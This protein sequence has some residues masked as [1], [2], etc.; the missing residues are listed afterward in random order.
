MAKAPAPF[1][2]P[3]DSARPPAPKRPPA[4]RLGGCRLPRR[5]HRRGGNSGQGSFGPTGEGSQR[6]ARDD[7]HAPRRP[8]RLLRLC[9]GGDSDSR[10]PG[11]ARRALP[12][13][14]RPRAPHRP[15]PRLDPDGPHAARPRHARQRRLRA[16][17]ER[18]HRGRGLPAGRLPHRGVRLGLSPE[19]PLRSS[20]AVSGPTTTT[21]PVA[22]TRAGRPTSSD[23]PTGRPTPPWPGSTP[24]KDPRRPSSSGCTTTTPT[25]PTSRPPRSRRERRVPLR[26]RDRVRGLTD[27]AL[28]PSRRRGKID[29]PHARA[30]DR[31][32]RREPRGARRG[33]PR[34][35]RL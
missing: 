21:C 22:T 14:H 4:G 31:G 25:P 32:P 8:P 18:A 11:R 13:G 34:H 33:H 26:R 20:T 2:S 24:R 6:S 12:H 3:A 5:R 9:P 1:P 19:Q 29:A 30:R 27:R 10:R 15:V 23:P 7:R 17:A 28:A 16:A 35:L